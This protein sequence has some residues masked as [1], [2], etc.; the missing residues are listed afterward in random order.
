MPIQVQLQGVPQLVHAFDEWQTEVKTPR[1]LFTNLVSDVIVPHITQ[2]F[3][4][5][6]PGWAP[7]SPAYAEWKQQHFPG[8]PILQRTG[9]LYGAMTSASRFGGSQSKISGDTLSIAP[10]VPYFRFHQQGTGRMPAR[11]MIDFSELEPKVLP[12][13]ENWLSRRARDLGFK[14]R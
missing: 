1:T 2:R 5:Q 4:A 11:P 7:L 8:K 6:G 10:T 12:Y 14:V 3:A 9:A 13:I